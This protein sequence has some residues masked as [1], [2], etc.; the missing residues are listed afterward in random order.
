M[1]FFHDDVCESGTC[2]P[3]MVCLHGRDPIGLLAMCLSQLSLW[4]SR[5]RKDAMESLGAS[6][7]GLVDAIRARCPW[8]RR[9]CRHLTSMVSW[10]LLGEGREPSFGL[11]PSIGGG[12]LVPA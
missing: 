8:G 7:S 6:I 12:D 5:R 10:S 11:L 2:E 1:D 9:C 3:P 4:I